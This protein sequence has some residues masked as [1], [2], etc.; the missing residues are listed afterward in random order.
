MKRFSCVESLLEKEKG[1]ITRKNGSGMLYFDFKYRDKRLE[2]ST[3]L[4]DNED[5]RKK[6]RE[7]LTILIERLERGIIGFAQAFP[8]ASE[9]EK[10]YFALLENRSY[11]REPW[12][13]CFGTYTEKWMKEIMANFPSE[14]KRHDYDQAI[15]DW[16]LPY[17]KDKSF[18]EVTT[19]EL[20]R[21][22]GKLKWRNTYR[23]G[24]PLSRS[25]ARNI[26]N[27]LRAIWADA[28]QDHHWQL[29]LPNPFTDLKPRDFP[30][31]SDM[32][33]KVFKF[34]EWLSVIEHMDPFY[35]PIAE[36]SI[37]TG[38]IGSEIAGL[39]KSDLKEGVIDVQNKI[40]RKRQKGGTLVIEST[41]LKT[42]GRDRRIPITEK[43]RKILEEVLSRTE[44]TFDYVFTMGDGSMY[45]PDNFREAAW[46]TAFRRAKVEYERP[47]GTRHT[48]AAWC[49][50][51]RMDPNRL[52]YL[53]GHMTKEM[54][55]ENY[56][57]YVEDM[58]KDAPSV[59]EY[60]GSDFIDRNFKRTFYPFLG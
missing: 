11:V 12:D 13:V 49:L 30:G 33:V 1:H 24:Q 5:N 42:S 57:K 19:V 43:I 56:G 10:A 35:R 20:K 32:I 34:D 55:W 53:M 48:F 44:S 39:R 58:E 14:N 38:M 51:L 7:A 54:I 41:N 6:A 45:D 9:K 27:P 59:L 15:N 4:P 47:Y 8:N 2:K 18:Y 28:V 17:F 36:F 29:K 46:K 25:R 26:F 50:M 23:E 37:L 22:I 31:K 52:V 16:I 3:G 21:F 60:F 40:V